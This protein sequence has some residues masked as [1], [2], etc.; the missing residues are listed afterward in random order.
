[1]NVQN[2]CW[3][4]VHIP[5]AEATGRGPSQVLT[6]SRH[7]ACLYNNVHNLLY[8]PPLVIFSLKSLLGNV[9]PSKVNDSVINSSMSLGGK[10]VSSVLS[11]MV[12]AVTFKTVLKP[13]GKISENMSSRMYNFSTPQNIRRQYELY[14]GLYGLK[15]TRGSCTM[16]SFVR[17]ILRKEIKRRRE[18]QSQK[19]IPPS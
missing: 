2:G 4:T 13:A 18:W 6:V 9:F 10:C 8:T 16:G 11:K 19:A 5:G 3:D 17:K 15:K 12:N 14:E 1:M 7:E